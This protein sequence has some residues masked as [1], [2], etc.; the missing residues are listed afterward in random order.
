LLS[1]VRRRNSAVAQRRV[2]T[3]SLDLRAA[4]GR[5]MPFYLV[6]VE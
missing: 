3:S 4:D 1:G 5:T 2:H 6:L